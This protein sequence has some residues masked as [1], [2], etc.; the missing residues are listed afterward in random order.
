MV[1][2]LAPG[3]RLSERAVNGAAPFVVRLG[4]YIDVRGAVVADQLVCVVCSAAPAFDVPRSHCDFVD[5]T[6]ALPHAH[7]PVPT[8]SMFWCR[9]AYAAVRV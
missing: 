4:Q 1:R 6:W 3:G 2:D 8:A 7:V 5:L 9:P